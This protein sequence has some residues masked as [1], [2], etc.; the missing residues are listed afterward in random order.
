MPKMWR[1]ISTGGLFL[2]AFG[3]MLGLQFD[4]AEALLLIIVA[5]LFEI[6][7]RLEE[8]HDET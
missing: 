7:G 1:W 4:R 6:A 8:A 3:P 5:Q 2:V